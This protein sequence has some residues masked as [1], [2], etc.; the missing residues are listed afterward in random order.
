MVTGIFSFINDVECAGA[1]MWNGILRQWKCLVVS[2]IS[3]ST[4]TT[5]TLDNS[6]LYMAGKVTSQSSWKQQGQSTDY[7]IARLNIQGYIEECL[8]TIEN[9][10]IT[11]R[12]ENITADSTNV[13][14]PDSGGARRL[15]IQYSTQM[16]SH[17]HVSR[18][19]HSTKKIKQP[20]SRHL[21]ASTQPPRT[22]T[23]QVEDWFA[24]HRQ[25]AT[26]NDSIVLKHLLSPTPLP[27]PAVR[28][29]S[30]EW[31]WLPNFSGTNGPVLKLVPGRIA[32]ENSLLISGQFTNYPPLLKWD[33]EMVI[34][35]DGLHH[36]GNT[37]VLGGRHELEGIISSM[38]EVFLPFE[39]VN[40]NDPPAPK[41]YSQDYTF[42]VLLACVGVGVLMGLGFTISC[43]NKWTLPV[44]PEG[45][46]DYYDVDETGS[47]HSGMSA[48]SL[49][50]LCDGQG[51]ATVDFREAFERAMKTRHLP[52]YEGMVI[53]NPK[54]IL[55]S[56]IIGE[57][58]FGRVWSG[59]WRNNAV[60][61]KEFVFAQ[62][63]I[64][65]GSLQ[66]N[67]I[68]EEIVG[69]AGVMACLRH[70]KILQL[71]GCS[72]TMQAIWIVSELCIRGSLKMV[73]MDQALDLP[74]VKRLS[75]CMDIA[76]GMQYLHNRSPP[77]I[78]RD[79]KS[80]NIF[81]SEPSP[82]HFVAKIGDW[83]SAR[84]VALTGAKNMT[85]GVGTACWLSPEVI[86]NAHF[87]KF[88]DVYAFGIILWE[89]YTRQ[90]IYEGL[91]AAQIIAKVANEGLRPHVPRDCPWSRIMTDCW[92]QDPVGRP[93]FQ[94]ILV[95]LSKIYLKLNSSVLRS[96]GIPHNISSG[97]S[98]NNGDDEGD[99]NQGEMQP[100][101]AVAPILEGDP[102]PAAKQYDTVHP[103]TQ[104]ALIKP[105]RS[106]ASN[107]APSPTGKA[108]QR[109]NLEGFH[110]SLENIAIKANDVVAEDR[111]QE[112]INDLYNM[113]YPLI[114]ESPAH[115]APEVA[116]AFLVTD[117]AGNLVQSTGT[118]KENSRTE[119]SFQYSEQ[120]HPADPL[121]FL[122]T[123][124]RPPPRVQRNIS[125][126]SQSDSDKTKNTDTTQIT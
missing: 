91:S 14:V 34:G 7:N 108:A 40:P 43:L 11:G 105:P 99:S 42:V 74:I 8:E 67:N 32:F 36:V 28:A 72:L 65:G 4:I 13:T 118:S 18:D 90:E 58:S 83:G 86:N 6:M 51:S 125:G 84:A 100:L 68:I 49:K 16:P 39:T 19:G 103:V 33:E 29:W 64:A 44:P 27:T 12:S 120:A 23:E 124:H 55:L 71:Y 104:F 111:K 61:V 123:A 1:A 114:E 92:K 81:I 45:G 38:A 66:R 77:I 73:L 78:H 35:N 53:I 25:Q 3:F 24:P 50:T 117:E 95:A 21:S 46:S 56:R 75:I 122:F 115:L 30:L 110:P 87:S 70:P 116:P 107:Y 22:V 10:E 79:L 93:N 9:M 2:D 89:V 57:G 62:A 59:Q 102:T 37:S 96:K 101:L 88:S 106:V 15:R 60:A 80:H 109:N 26:S 126:G 119:R 113:L 54:E 85:H 76:D 97:G 47:H 98:L 63:A 82:G 52:T 48:F 20:R 17:H 94:T 41:P 31:E 121:D 5:V 112:C 69:E